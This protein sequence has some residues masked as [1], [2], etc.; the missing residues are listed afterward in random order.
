M[1]VLAID[2]GATKTA[3]AHVDGAGA[4][5]DSRKVA[6]ADLFRSASTAVE[7]LVCAIQCFCESSGLA[8][9][10]LEGIGIGI[11]GLTD[12]ANDVI[13]YCP[14][15]P[16]LL[17]LRLGPD[18]QARLG[19]PVR[20]ENDVNLICLGEQHAGRGRGIS[21]VACVFVGS[22]IGCGLV[23]NGCLH[24]GP[25]GTVGELGHIVIEP[26]GLEC[27]CGGRGCLEMY[28]SGKA[29]ALRAGVLFGGGSGA[30]RLL[31]TGPAV[32]CA[33]AETLIN[34]AKAGHTQAVAELGRAF[35]YLG[36]GIANLVNI[37]DPR[38]IILGGSIVANWPPGIGIV[39]ET[40]RTRATPLARERIVIDG[41]ELGE[42]GG[43]VGA[44][45]LVRDWLADQATRVPG[46]P[47]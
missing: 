35:Y 17:G 37:I 39:R 18:L 9:A 10:S 16:A 36:L 2:I 33:D 38:L 23:V 14:N 11:P 5:L 30:G 31:P 20:V 21:D 12:R 44:A 43:L 26:E 15:L 28:C 40:V 25:D 29:L 4:I 27:T 3:I 1:P 8:L 41:P 45:F 6:S 7:A 34:A 19:V 22:G 13:G 47:V 24:T 46:G 42:K 32:P